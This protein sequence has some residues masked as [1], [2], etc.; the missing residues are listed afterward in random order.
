MVSSWLRL[1][2]VP[3]A[4]SAVTDILAGASVTGPT[5]FRITW[6]LLI[7]ASASLCLYAG[8]MVLN[9][10]V[11]RDEDRTLAP[12]RPLPRGEISL[13]AARAAAIVAPLL[14]LALASLLSARCGALV[15]LIEAIILVYHVV[16]KRSVWL[17]PFSLGLIRA[18]NLL[19][20]EVVMLAPQEAFSSASLVFPLAYAAYV[21]GASLVAALEDRGFD[22]LRF[23]LGVALPPAALVAIVP[24]APERGLPPVGQL[25]AS[26]PAAVYLIFVISRL[27]RRAALRASLAPLRPFAGLLLLGCYVFAATVAAGVGQMALAACILLLFVAS[28]RLATSFSPS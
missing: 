28:R 17:G 4:A 10:I 8:G 21:F 19:V 27:P 2:R 5:H 24:L 9:A 22:A 7:A 25:V 11:D 3:L 6:G 14:A 1:V 13:R 15:L 23:W 18:L 16:L 20:G 12:H 26:L